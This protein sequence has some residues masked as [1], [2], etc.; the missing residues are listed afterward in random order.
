VKQSLDSRWRGNDGFLAPNQL[1][2]QPLSPFSAPSKAVFAILAAALACTGHAAD[3]PTSTGRNGP[4]LLRVIQWRRYSYFAASGCGT[5]QV[6]ISEVST[7]TFLTD[8][9]DMG[10]EWQLSAP[11]QSLCAKHSSHNFL[12][13]LQPAIVNPNTKA[14][15]IFM[16]LFPH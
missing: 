4:C 1:F 6:I 14:S 8:P 9:S 3:T 10:R 13:L 16:I 15:N 2:S 5:G 7:H 11:S 12:G